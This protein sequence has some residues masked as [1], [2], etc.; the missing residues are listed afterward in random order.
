MPRDGSVTFG[1]LIGK[2]DV[3]R[4]ECA[5]AGA[6]G[7]IRCAGWRW[8]TAARVRGSGVA[9]GGLDFLAGGVYV[10]KPG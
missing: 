3:L 2:L 9:V 4:V 10:A 7:A 6:P 1:D 8:S 5:S